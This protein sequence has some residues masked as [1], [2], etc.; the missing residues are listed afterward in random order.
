MSVRVTGL[1]AMIMQ[2]R[3]R[4]CIRMNRPKTFGEFMAYYCEWF[5]EDLEFFWFDKFKSIAKSVYK[6]SNIDEPAYR[7]IKEICRPSTKDLY[8]VAVICF[9]SPDLHLKDRVIHWM[10]LAKGEAVSNSYRLRNR[11]CEKVDRVTSS[12][13]RLSTSQ[14]EDLWNECLA[15][16]RYPDTPSDSDG[17]IE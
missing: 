11:V 15:N 16:R 4:S 5:D 3:T 1:F 9:Y 8:A 2:M 7:G 17:E 12:T 13:S 10:D 6:I 14:L